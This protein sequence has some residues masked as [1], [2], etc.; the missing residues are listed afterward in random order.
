MHQCINYMC[1]LCI[2]D[3]KDVQREV[4][5]PFTVCLIYFD[6]VIFE[7]LVT[8]WDKTLE[9]LSVFCLTTSD[10]KLPNLNFRAIECG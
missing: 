3:G 10:V 1:K 6:L 2:S 4:C 5:N 9:A 8:A 7:F